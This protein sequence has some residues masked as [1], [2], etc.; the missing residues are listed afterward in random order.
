M[1]TWH[2]HCWEWCSGCRHWPTLGPHEAKGA[3]IVSRCVKWF[4]LTKISNSDGDW[5]SG[6]NHRRFASNY[7]LMPVMSRST[8]YFISIHYNLYQFSISIIIIYI[9]IIHYPII[10]AFNLA[11]QLVTWH[12]RSRLAPPRAGQPD[13]ERGW[14]HCR[15]LRR[16]ASGLRWV[17]KVWVV[18]FPCSWWG[19][20]MLKSQQ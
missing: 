12:P 11:K 5:H 7:W 1:G 20:M 4:I 6:A 10:Y 8:K 14:L 18:A 13:F 19:R 15:L 3:K 2:E 17:F 9:L 16:F